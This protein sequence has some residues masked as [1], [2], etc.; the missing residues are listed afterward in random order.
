MLYYL[1][2]DIRWSFLLYYYYLF[3]YFFCPGNDLAAFVSTHWQNLSKSMSAKKKKKKKKKK[4]QQKT[5][6]KKKTTKNNK[7]CIVWTLIHLL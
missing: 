7:T 3:I 2:L 4:N 5:K 1:L 6:K